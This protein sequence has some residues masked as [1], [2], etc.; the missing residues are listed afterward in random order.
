MPGSEEMLGPTPL[1]PHHSYLLLQFSPGHLNTVASKA[2]ASLER[3][4]CSL[5]LGFSLPANSGEIE[6]CTFHCSAMI[7]S[8]VPAFHQHLW[9]A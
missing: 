4:T 5:A 8:G 3:I 7:L 2:P 9:D 1:P 6:V